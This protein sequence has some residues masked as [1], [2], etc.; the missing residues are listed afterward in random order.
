MKNLS[1]SRITKKIPAPDCGA[2]DG[3]GQCGGALK[4]VE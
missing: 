3:A 1:I 2:M 4:A